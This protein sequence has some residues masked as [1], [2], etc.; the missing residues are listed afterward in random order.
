MMKAKCTLFASALGVLATLCSPVHLRAQ[1]TDIKFVLDWKFEGEHAQFTV[2]AEDGTFKRYKLNVQIDRGAGSGDTVTKVGSGAYDMGYAD[3]YAM[4]RFNAANPDRRLIAVAMNQ[5]TSAMGITT[6][7]SSSIKVP[8]D[9]QGKRV[10]SP[11]DAGK[12]LFPL[13]AAIN[14]IDSN[15]IEWS[16]VAPDLRDTMLVRGK[17]DA[18]TGNVTTTMMNAR[19]MG[20]PENGL[21]TFIYSKF[22]VPLYG[23]AIITTPAFAEA[24]PEAIRNF[25][26]GV[27]HGLDQMVKDPV[28]ALATLKKRDPLLD[29][30]IEMDRLKISLEYMLITDHVLQHGYSQ[31]DSARLQKTLDDVAGPFNLKGAPKASDVYTDAYLPPATELKISPWKPGK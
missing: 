3:I 27:A 31:V 15:K 14:G 16:N 24:H 28:G 12:Q 10:G 19:A 1:E 30:K 11:Q 17:A 4:V 29:D 21:R 18:V 2:P 20:V 9:L 7:A 8:T 25:I 26:R 5:D 23:S 6:L 22:G 13:F